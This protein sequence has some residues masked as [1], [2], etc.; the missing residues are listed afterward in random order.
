MHQDTEEHKHK[1]AST[2]LWITL[3]CI[4]L[5]VLEKLIY[6]PLSPADMSVH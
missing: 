6:I 2:V 1:E 5:V 4:S 3:K